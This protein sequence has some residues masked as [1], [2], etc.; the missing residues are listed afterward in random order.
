MNS[1]DIIAEHNPIVKDVPARLKWFSQ[2]RG[3]GFVVLDNGREAFLLYDVAKQ[4]GDVLLKGDIPLRV[5]V[6]ERRKGWVVTAVSPDSIPA[7]VY[8]KARIGLPDQGR[9]GFCFVDV[10]GY[11]RGIFLH[12]EVASYFGYPEFRM[13]PDEFEVAIGNGPRGLFVESISP[14]GN[15]S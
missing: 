6:T 14:R 3:Y 4:L 9:R 12:I 5:D 1:A 7:L 2:N 10:E 13:L 8:H 11:E 15:A